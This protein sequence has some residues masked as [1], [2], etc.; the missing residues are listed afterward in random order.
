MKIRIIFLIGLVLTALG[1]C[2]QD[3][4]N[5][6]YISRPDITVDLDSSYTVVALKDTLDITVNPSPNDEYEYLWLARGTRI[7][8]DTLGKDAHLRWKV[9]LPQ[10]QYDLYLQLTSKKDGY[11]RV[12]QSDLWV[13]S[14]YSDGW[15]ILKEQNGETDLD[16]HSTSDSG[17]VIENILEN[18]IGKKM[19]GRAGDMSLLTSRSLPNPEGSF[20]YENL[21]WMNSQDETWLVRTNDMSLYHDYSQMFY[22]EAPAEKPLWFMAYGYRGDLLCNKQGVYY[23][24]NQGTSTLQFG[25]PLDYEKESEIGGYGFLDQIGGYYFYDEK[26]QRFLAASQTGSPLIFETK[27]SESGEFLVDVNN[28]GCSMLYMGINTP[29]SERAY[30][31]MWDGNRHYIYTLSVNGNISWAVPYNPIIDVKTLNNNKL[32]ESTHFAIH[33]SLPYIYYTDASG[34]RVHYYDILGRSFVENAIELPAGEKVS[35]MKALFFKPAN[36]EGAFDKFVV[37]TEKDGHY[38]VYLYD[39]PAGKPTTAPQIL[40]GNG[41]VSSIQR[42]CKTMTSFSSSKMSGNFGIGL[43]E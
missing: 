29:E 30:A 2:Y 42:V 11:L 28:T 33:A 34:E 9:N 22:G 36:G 13:T 8:F 4:G 19:H 15:F 20:I 5:Y 27:Q 6:D 32:N 23:G 12:F 18:A 39:M 31:L 16:F 37:A 10:G 38:K 21:L 3:K 1:A 41:K 35:F 17:E 7:E 24:N 25:M 26:N 40:E 43:F 14:N